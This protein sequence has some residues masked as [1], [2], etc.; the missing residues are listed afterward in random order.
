M[1]KTNSTKNSMKRNGMIRRILT[2]VLTA[3]MMLISRPVDALAAGT[4]DIY[5]RKTAASTT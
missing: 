4:W 5:I 3:I 2:A 1:T